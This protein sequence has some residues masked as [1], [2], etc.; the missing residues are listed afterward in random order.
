ML[1]AAFLRDDKEHPT[2]TGDLVLPS[3]SDQT[4][5]SCGAVA[6]RTGRTVLLEARGPF[7]PAR[8]QIEYV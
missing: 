7:P 4:C 5:P 2:W 8:F 6:Y 1:E 3:T